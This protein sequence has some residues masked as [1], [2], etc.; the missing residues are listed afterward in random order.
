MKFGSK[1]LVNS[2]AF[3]L[4]VTRTGYWSELLLKEISGRPLSGGTLS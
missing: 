1:V 2:F 4:F 3:I